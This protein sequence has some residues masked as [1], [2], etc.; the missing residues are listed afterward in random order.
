MNIRIAAISA[1]CLVF[2]INASP[3]LAKKSNLTQ[4][5]YQYF[6]AIHQG[7]ITKAR[8]LASL[9]NIDPDNVGGS[10][11]VANL[12]NS[13]GKLPASVAYLSDEA[14]DYVFKELKQPFNAKME[15]GGDQTV[16]SAM[17][18]AFSRSNMFQPVNFDD[19]YSTIKR[20]KFA[21]SQGADPHPLSGIPDHMRKNQPFPACVREYLRYRHIPQVA[22]AILSV[23]NDY[24]EKGVDPDYQQPIALAAEN[25]DAELFGLLAIHKANFGRVFQV[26]G[27]IPHACNRG[28]GLTSITSELPQRD[29]L[30]G[31]LPT[32]KD[33]EMGPARDFLIAYIEAGGSITEKQNRFGLN[34]NRCEHTTSTLFEKAVS[35]G[36]VNYAKMVQELEK[37]RVL[38][39]ALP[40]AAAN[41]PSPQAPSP[42]AQPLYGSRVTTAEIN[43]RDQPAITGNLMSTLGPNIAF[44]IEETSPDG[45]WSRINAEPIVRGWANNGV[46][47]KS[48]TSNIAQ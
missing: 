47:R 14:F 11:L 26:R 15:P 39:K 35:N 36:Q 1:S 31:L 45:A 20:I 25:L 7:N 30:L 44:D 13:G 16:F 33:S 34:G 21:F 4:L 48:S 32:P 27:N 43:V 3:A 38:H 17:C 8:E 18:L 37:Q 24:L 9:G 6:A 41:P 29:T 40:F 42:P 23:L 28:R 22:G 12:F 10:P 46:I 19:V 2:A 5:H